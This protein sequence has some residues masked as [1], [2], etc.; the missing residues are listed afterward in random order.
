MVRGWKLALVVVLGLVLAMLPMSSTPAP[1]A[2]A[3][4]EKHKHIQ[5][6]LDELRDAKSDLKEADHDF[7]GHRKEAIEA[8][9][10]AISQ[11]KKCLEF[12]K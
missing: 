10:V 2:A 9:D 7:G 1:A 11:L 12:D 5:Q 8:I 6:A 4:A 3:V